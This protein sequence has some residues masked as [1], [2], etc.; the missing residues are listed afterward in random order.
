MDS[1][2]QLAVHRLLQ[3]AHMK[4]VGSACCA[5]PFLQ[6]SFA[7]HPMLSRV[8]TSDCPTSFHACV[9]LALV[10]VSITPAR[11]G[12]ASLQSSRQSRIALCSAAAVAKL[13]ACMSRRN[14]DGSPEMSADQVRASLHRQQPPWRVD[15]TAAECVHLPYACL[16]ACAAALAD[17]RLL[18]CQCS[19]TTAASCCHV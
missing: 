14:S 18:S 10:G 12:V 19:A 5:Q 4:K 16:I 8:V 13:G 7:A 3:P 15:A 2:A 6:E 11:S 17:V 9:A 1:S